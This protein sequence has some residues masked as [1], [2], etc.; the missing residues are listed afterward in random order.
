M[1]A[2]PA[3]GV[4]NF[5]PHNEDNVSFVKMLCKLHSYSHFSQ[6]PESS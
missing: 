1:I 4:V 2:M 3:F 6:K 5:D